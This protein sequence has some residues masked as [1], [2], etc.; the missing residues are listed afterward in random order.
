MVHKE[1][2]V[3]KA[4]EDWTAPPIC[5][6]SGTTTEGYL[7]DWFRAQG[8]SFTPV[9]AEDSDQMFSMYF[10]NRCDAVTMEPPYLAI[11]RARSENPDG[12][13]DPRHE[14]RQVLRGAGDP[15]GQ[16]RSCAR[17][18]SGCTGAW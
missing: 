17:C 13:V 9:A 7:A 3:T 15:R 4:S 11:R 14:H 8:M 18:C 12:H 16:S 6:L 1:T 5:V 2:G 10:D